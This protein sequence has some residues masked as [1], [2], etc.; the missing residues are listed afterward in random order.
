MFSWHAAHFFPLSS[1]SKVAAEKRLKFVN[2]DQKI[3]SNG[4][5]GRVRCNIDSFKIIMGNCAKYTT[6]GKEGKM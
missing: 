6:V 4:M 3:R 2:L 5:K 1:A